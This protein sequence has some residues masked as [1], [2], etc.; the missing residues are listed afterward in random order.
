MHSDQ[1]LPDLLHL[2]L[3]VIKY[4][5]KFSKVEEA[6][7]RCP[8]PPSWPSQEGGVYQGSYTLKE[9]REAF[10]LKYVA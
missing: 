5:L 10:T 1:G 6:V 7:S 2:L 8:C 3:Q 9:V 4:Q